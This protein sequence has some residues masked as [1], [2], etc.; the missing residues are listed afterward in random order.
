MN[1]W[2]DDARAADSWSLERTTM[3]PGG[4]GAVHTDYTQRAK[5]SAV[6]WNPDAAGA[7][8]DLP[9]WRGMGFLVP[10]AGSHAVQHADPQLRINYRAGPVPSLC[11]WTSA[12]CGL[13]PPDG[14]SRVT[15]A[16]YPMHMGA[17]R[18]CGT[19]MGIW[20]FIK[21]SNDGII[22]TANHNRQRR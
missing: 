14:I 3:V 21:A 7:A 19:T 15:G 12:L 9:P 4:F 5:W 20:G 10:D 2:L 16:L 17:G 13:D 22:T 18:G 11:L 1:P 8:G 6:I